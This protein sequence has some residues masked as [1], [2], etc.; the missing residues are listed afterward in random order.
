MELTLFSAKSIL[1]VAEAS[2][3]AV[4]EEAAEAIMV[5]IPYFAKS[6]L[7]VAEVSESAVALVKQDKDACCV[8]D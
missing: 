8:S 4:A 6:I 3:S 7:D 2:E 1:D 5:L